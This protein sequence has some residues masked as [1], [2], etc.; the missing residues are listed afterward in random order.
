MFDS[1]DEIKIMTEPD[2]ETKNI[3]MYI[4][5]SILDRC[6]FLCLFLLL[7]SPR[8]IISVKSTGTRGIPLCITVPF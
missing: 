5:V 3:N 7:L 6:M 1:I 8:L 4:V 2:S